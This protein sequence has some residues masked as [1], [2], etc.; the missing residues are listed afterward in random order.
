MEPT[1]AV[2]PDG[3][4]TDNRE[5]LLDLLN[6][7]L[8]AAYTQEDWKRATVILIRKQDKPSEEPEYYHPI[9]LTSCLGKIMERIIN[10]R[11]S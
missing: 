7:M 1:G 9:S 8:H 4:I 11:I 6:T 5:H 2:L 10:R 3:I